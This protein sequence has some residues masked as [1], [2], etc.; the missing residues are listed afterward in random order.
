MR[1]YTLAAD[2]GDA[3][4]QYN[5]GAMYHTGN[6]VVQDYTEAMRY[7]TLAAD[8]GNADAQNKICKVYE[9]PEAC[10]QIAS[11]REMARKYCLGCGKKHKL[12]ICARCKVARFC[13]TECVQRTWKWHK[14][15]CKMWE[16]E[17]E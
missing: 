2:Q 9:S 7:Y 14:P 16:N 12:K 17:C 10:R 3:D 11:N 4:A 13:S 6:G 15:H 1:Y 8:Q 5:L